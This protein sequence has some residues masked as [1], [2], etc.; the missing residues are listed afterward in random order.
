MSLNLSLVDIMRHKKLKGTK[1][2]KEQILSVAYEMGM[3]INKGVQVYH[4][5]YRSQFTG[6]VHNGKVYLGT[7]RTDEDWLVTKYMV[8]SLERFGHVF[9]HMLDGHSQSFM[10][11][12]KDKQLEYFGGANA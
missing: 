7:E 4:L 3:D 10:A 5:L 12:L 8:N 6:Q 11:T 2:S 1:P 9:G